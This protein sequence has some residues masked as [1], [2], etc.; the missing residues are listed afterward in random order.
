MVK[1]YHED[2]DDYKL[3]IIKKIYL[4]G[5]RYNFPINQASLG[6]I[7]LIDGIDSIIKKGSAIITNESTNDTKDIDK[8]SFVPSIPHQNIQIIQCLKLLLNQ[9]FHQNYQFY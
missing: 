9:K 2:K 6:N 4:P 8:L 5:G 7:V 1:N 3:E